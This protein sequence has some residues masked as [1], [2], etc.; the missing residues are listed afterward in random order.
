[1]RRLHL[2]RELD[3]HPDD[4]PQASGRLRRRP[5]GGDLDGLGISHAPEPD[6]QIRGAV[7][8]LKVVDDDGNVSLRAV[9]SPGLSWLERIGMLREAERAETTRH[10]GLDD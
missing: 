1:M 7:V 4:T 2:Q 6:E 5:L 8:L 3:V 9:W 10:L